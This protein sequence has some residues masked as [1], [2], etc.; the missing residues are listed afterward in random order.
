MKN[1][2]EQI[3]NSYWGKPEYESYLVITCHE[4]RKKN[5]NEFEVEDLRIMIGQNIALPIL[6]P[7]AITELRKNIFAE[8]HFYEG[9]LLRN[10][11]TSEKEFWD[12]HPHYK[13]E[14]IALLESNQE[15]IR[16]MDTTCEIENSILN[17]IDAFS[18]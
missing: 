12:K 18:E 5:L 11:L 13:K 1:T 15:N 6:I 8:G 2:I 17:A 7:M 4:L 3:E 10:V 16:N 9:D 14:M